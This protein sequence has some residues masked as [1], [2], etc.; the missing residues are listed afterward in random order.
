MKTQDL[1][2]QLEKLTKFLGKKEFEGNEIVT[3]ISQ[4]VSFFSLLKV[5]EIIISGFIEPFKHVDKIKNSYGA[6]YLADTE[7][8]PF[9]YDETNK[10]YKLEN[11]SFS[12]KNF[13]K[14]T[15][16]LSIAFV[17]AKKIIENY[18]DSEKLIPKSLINFFESKPKFTPIHSSLQLMEQNYEAKDSED[19]AANSIAL[20][21]S[22]LGL[23]STL[24]GK[25]LSKQISNIKCDKTLL[26]K[27]GVRSEVITAL[28][29]SRI[30]RNYLT[31]HK[32]IPIEY[33]VPFAVSLGT[34]Y[35]VIMFLQITMST[36]E[37][38]K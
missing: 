13:H 36:G 22:I 27:F 10:K 33:N 32:S 19:L 29:N 2:N 24:I 34:A 7:I 30:L 31:S 3:W 16:P 26:D 17:T 21:G 35:L 38:I 11:F 23:E 14:E 12:W 4:C 20:L 8:G 18:E 15:L 1:K 9:V 25:D 5:N 37:L 28:D 6:G